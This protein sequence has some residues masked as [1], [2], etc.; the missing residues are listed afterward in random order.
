MKENKQ[1]KKLTLVYVFYIHVRKALRS[2][3]YSTFSSEHSKINILYV[4]E[5]FIFKSR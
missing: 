1:I 3:P 2:F 5:E 4:C